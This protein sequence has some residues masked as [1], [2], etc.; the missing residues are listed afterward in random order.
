MWRCTL[1][2]V[3]K[4]GFAEKMIFELRKKS[5]MLRSEERVAQAEGSSRTKL[6]KPVWAWALYI[7]MDHE[8][9]EQ[10]DMQR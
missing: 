6:I 4:K 1:H 7:W 2:R 5:V 9:Q 10:T 3:I 8:S